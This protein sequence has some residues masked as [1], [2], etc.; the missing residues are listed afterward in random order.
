VELAGLRRIVGEKPPYH[1]LTFDGCL[2]SSV[3]L[4]LFA[5]GHWIPSVD[6]FLGVGFR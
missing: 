2:P 6:T 5:T 1:S 3:Q 4:V